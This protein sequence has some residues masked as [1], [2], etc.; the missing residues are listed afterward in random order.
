[1]RKHART[2]EERE[3]RTAAIKAAALDIFAQKG[4]AATRLDDIAAAAGV[5]KGTIYLYFNSKQ[6]LFESLV[7]STI[8]VA[9]QQVEQAIGA[10]P[11]PASELL[12]L[13]GQ[14]ISASIQDPDRRRVLLLVFSEGARFPAIAEFYHREIISRGIALMRAIIAKGR[15][16]GEFSHDEP[17]RFP[18]LVIAPAL[19]A[20]I[21]SATFD[22]F[23]KLDGPGLIAAHF[24]MM[25]RALKRS[26]LMK[27]KIR[28]ILPV[29]LLLALGFAGFRIFSAPKTQDFFAGYVEGDLVQIGPIEGERLARL[30]VEPGAQVQKG[31]PLFKMATPVL[32]QSRAEAVGRT[33]QARANL[34]NLK[35]A[36]NRPEQ[37]AV[38]Q[39]GLDRAKAALVLS[40]AEYE[41]Q[42]T[43]LA[44]G[45]ASVAT[46]DQAKFAVDRDVAGVAEAQRQIDAALLPSRNQEIT[47]AEAAIVQ[48]EAQTRQ[49]DV[50]IARQSVFA[51]ADGVIQ[52]VFFRPGEVVAAG[53]PVLAL[54][55]PQ[56]RKIRFFVPETQL[57]N[58]AL[59]KQV[60]VACDTCPAG[61]KAR[62]IYISPQAEFTPPVIFSLDERGKLAFRID[63]RPEDQKLNLPLGLPITA[64]LAGAA[65]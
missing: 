43:L 15:A 18:Q 8:G 30:E 46:R 61:I 21:W 20:V 55:P 19:V 14:T 9:L 25:L 2:T 38:L 13:L 40:Q 26:E 23:E 37:I 33:E 49:I 27:G 7:A 64:R 32:D 62:V 35:A 56:N 12:R 53:Q 47:A 28:F 10:S 39:A 6:A 50:R 57:A 1:M 36:L 11:A 48:A 17:A 52:D 65:P 22:R 29:I 41:R 5:A 34:D 16:S 51:P 45:V 3:A 60:E 44:K 54:L 4:F 59:G 24:E 58:F 63:A 42:A 31:A